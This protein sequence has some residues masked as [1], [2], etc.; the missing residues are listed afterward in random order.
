[1]DKSACAL[2]SML[3]EIEFLEKDMKGYGTYSQK[4][5]HF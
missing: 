2:K 4:I 1:M 5:F 3:E